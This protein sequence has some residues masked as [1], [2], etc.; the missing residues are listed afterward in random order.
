MMPSLSTARLAAWR[1]FR[2]VKGLGPPRAAWS[3][4]SMAVRR[5]GEV[6][7][8]ATPDFSITSIWSGG[9]ALI[10][11]TPPES[12]SAISVAF[13]GMMRMRRYL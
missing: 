5:M 1:T 3:S 6:P 4:W 12:S 11:S 7:V 10:T 8:R 13:S 9:T 2:S